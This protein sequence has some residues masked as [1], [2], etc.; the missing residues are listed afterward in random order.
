ML[1]EFHFDGRTGLGLDCREKTNQH[2]QISA[3]SQPGSTGGVSRF[4]FNRTTLLSDFP[5]LIRI[6]A[7]SVPGQSSAQSVHQHALSFTWGVERMRA[8]SS[9]ATFVR[10]GSNAK[11]WLLSMCHQELKYCSTKYTAVENFVE[12]L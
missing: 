6:D 4:T 1:L 3:P 9:A 12:S 11:N 8:I 7:F 10:F 2:Q 5:I